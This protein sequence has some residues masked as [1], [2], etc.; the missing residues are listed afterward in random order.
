M[1]NDGNGVGNNANSSVRSKYGRAV[2]TIIVTPNAVNEARFGWFNDKQFDYPNDALAIP[3]IGLLGISITG[4]INLG[5]RHDYPR[6]NPLENRY[7]FTDTLSWTTGK[8]SLKF[9]FDFMNT[10]DFTNVAIQQNGYL[11]IPEFHSSRT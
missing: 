8:H 4:Q 10:N 5:H 11:P 7:Q 9:G 3:G 6:L 1:L 2:W